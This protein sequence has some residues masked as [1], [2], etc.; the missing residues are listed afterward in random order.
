MMQTEVDRP[1]LVEE[2]V[3]EAEVEEARG[4]L[5]G[6]GGRNRGLEA[7]ESAGRGGGESW[8]SNRA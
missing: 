2:E 8:R 6:G 5:G 3:G 4:D 1:E 7:A